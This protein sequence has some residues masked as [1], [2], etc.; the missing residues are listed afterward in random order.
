MGNWQI[1]L[2]DSK[3]VNEHFVPLNKLT[4]QRWSF[5]ERQ[6]AQLIGQTVCLFYISIDLFANVVK[7]CLTSRFQRSLATIT[8]FTIFFFK[9]VQSFPYCFTHYRVFLDKLHN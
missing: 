7:S 4:L 3:Y 9:K 6:P 8:I 5:S 1:Y 2:K